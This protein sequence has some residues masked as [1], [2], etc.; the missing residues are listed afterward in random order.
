MKKKCSILLIFLLVIICAF[1]LTG[2]SG[3]TGNQDGTKANFVGGTTPY[4]SLK[5][6]VKKFPDRTTVQNYGE[7]DNT[8]NCANWLADKF[9]EYGYIPQY[10]NG[11]DTFNFE[12]PLVNK[13]TIGY[14]VVF[15]KESASDK[16]VVIGASYDN[17]AG[18]KSNGNLIGGDGSYDSGVGIAT[19]LE[20]AKVLKDKSFDFDIEFVAFGA[21]EAG[22]I[23]SQRYLNNVTDK[24]KII[25]MINFDRNAIGDYVYMY[26][27]EATTKHNEFFYQKAKENNLCIAELPSYR[28]PYLDQYS[29]NSFYSTELNWS[30]GEVFLDEGINMISFVSMNFGSSKVVER[31]GSDNILYTVRD[32]FDDIVER[33]GGI[34][35][36][37]EMIDKQIN[38]AISSVVYAL[39]DKNF[40]NVMSTSKANG[41]LDFMLNVDIWMYVT[42]GI[43]VGVII[44]CVILY[45]SLKGSCKRHDVYIDTIYGRVN[46]STGKLED[47]NTNQQNTSGESVGSVFGSEFEGQSKNSNNHNANNNEPTIGETK[48]SSSD[49][50]KDIFGDF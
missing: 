26:S 29:S 21:K 7:E 30:D 37:K 6:F 27:S 1:S 20:T 14:N 23:G 36:A 35:K 10:D 28:F 50:T 25:L 8:L 22:L 2:C 13:T 47:F 41:G 39:E 40:V 17:V 46:T 32:N 34:E 44:L 9:I 15:K 16:K 33:L 31:A 49:K 12:N 43:T 19:L 3:N 45:F 5:E 24:D 42:F 18:Y 48:S 4:E 38:S 11:I